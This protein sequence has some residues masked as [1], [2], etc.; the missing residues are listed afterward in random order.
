MNPWFIQAEAGWVQEPDMALDCT[1][2]CGECVECLA[3][4]AEDELEALADDARKE[5]NR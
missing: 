1:D 5:R 4:A 2:D 3:I